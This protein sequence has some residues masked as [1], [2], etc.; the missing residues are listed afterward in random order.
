[1]QRLQDCST[2]GFRLYVT[3]QIDPQKWPAFEEKMVGRYE[4]DMSNSTRSKRRRKGESVVRL[5]AC[6]VPGGQVVWS[7]MVTPGKGRIHGQEDLKDIE[8]IRLELGGF[9][10][11]H[12]G[13]CW[14]WKMTSER[15]RYWRERIVEI[16]RRPPH[17]RRV[18]KEEGSLRGKDA[19]I[20]GVMDS[21]YSQP[22]FRLVRRDVGELVAFANGVWGRYRPATGPQIS[23]RTYLP[24][25]R[26]LPN[27]KVKNEKQPMTNDIG[28]ATSDI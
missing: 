9:E 17:R 6:E 27:C 4:L 26:R 28:K 21:L 18:E 15:K 12:D 16:A 19:E 23:K 20:E 13:V 25:V 8:K 11:V 22:G 7:M 24:Y 3:G 2:K 10:L 1:M 14:T 5:Y